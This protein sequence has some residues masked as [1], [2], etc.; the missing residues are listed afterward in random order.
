MKCTW[1]ISAR[2]PHM[3]L[4]R[5]NLGQQNT[6]LTWNWHEYDFILA[7][8]QPRIILKHWHCWL[9]IDMTQKRFG[10]SPHFQ[11]FILIYRYCWLVMQNPIMT[12]ICPTQMP[13]NWFKTKKTAPLNT[14]WVSSHNFDVSCSIVS[15]D[16]PWTYDCQEFSNLSQKIRLFQ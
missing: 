7:D 12:S 2:F 10:M 9:Y 4:F 16:D 15:H 8:I 13:N 6:T 1:A 11:N 14:I 5:I 3:N